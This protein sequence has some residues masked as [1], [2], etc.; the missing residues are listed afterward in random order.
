M[1]FAI[2]I[3]ACV[4]FLSTKPNLVFAL[5]STTRNSHPTAT[6][7]RHRNEE[8]GLHDTT[9]IEKPFETASPIIENNEITASLD[10]IEK[11]AYGPDK[12]LWQP[13]PTTSTR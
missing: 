3:I 13:S 9:Y 6:T 8:R 1:K 4:S 12:K 7:K 5:E 2:W 10:G 11:R